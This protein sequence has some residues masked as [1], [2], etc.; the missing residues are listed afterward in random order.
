M[1]YLLFIIILSIQCTRLNAQ[2]IRDTTNSLAN[3]DSVVKQKND[4]LIVGHSIIINKNRT[5]EALIERNKFINLAEPVSIIATQKQER[6]R[7]F[8]FYLIAFICLLTGM[9][10][11]FYSRYYNTI[12][13]VYFNTS[14]R[15]NQLTDLL[16]QAKLSSLIFNIL[17]FI[18]GACY[19]DL[20]IRQ[21]HL[22]G[23]FGG[24]MLLS[25]VLILGLIYIVK[26]LAVR[27]IGWIGDMKTEAETYIFIVFLI[28]KIIG[29]LLLPFI[30]LMAFSPPEWQD[31]LGIGSGLM[32]LM[33]L[34]SR[35]FRSYGL[36][37]QKLKL[38]PLHFLIY[39]ISFEIL[40]VII[41]AKIGSQILIN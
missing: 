32:V 5:P 35:F 7:E 23:T 38:S 40:P 6:G 20:L 36:L 8:L 13:K 22:K 27:F 1:K 24:L 28:N 21:Y 29:I 10:K 15:Q 11:I 17:F 4:H 26:Y 3:M 39:L 34:L 14:I 33:L 31:V 18:N 19:A 9:A 12:F 41:L 37:H 2:G 16:L 30:I 25:S